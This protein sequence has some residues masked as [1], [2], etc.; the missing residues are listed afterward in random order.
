MTQ[1]RFM[2]VDVFSERPCFG[3]GLGVVVDADG[4]SVG[5]MQQF[6]HWIGLSECAFLCRPSDPAA[7]Y[8]VRIFTPT[9]ELPFAGHP[10]LGSCAAWRAAGG[11]P[12]AADRVV[13]ECGVGLVDIVLSADAP[14]FIAPPAE[15]SPLPDGRAAHIADALGIAADRVVASARIVCGPEFQVLELASATDVLAARAEGASAPDVTAVGLIG[16][17]AAAGPADYEVRHLE[18]PSEA[19]EDPVTGS[20]NAGLA[21]WLARRGRLTAPYVAAQGTVLGREGRVFVAPTSDAARI[22]VGGT[23]HIIVDGV[24]SL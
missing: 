24:I 12:R 8:A 10:T 18:P 20:L 14:A 19:G 6:A 7:D 17:H 1:R 15:I 23:S 22:L 13:Q 16:P 21:H 9:R 11:A 2:L 4:L 5:A 3:N